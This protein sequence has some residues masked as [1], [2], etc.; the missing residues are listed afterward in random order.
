MFAETNTICRQNARKLP[1]NVTRKYYPVRATTPDEIPKSCC[2]EN[3]PFD[4]ILLP[5]VFLLAE[6]W[7]RQQP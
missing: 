6:G 3:R 4:R 1:F 5:L 2:G 7:A